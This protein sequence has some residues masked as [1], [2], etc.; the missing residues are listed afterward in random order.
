VL[1]DGKWQLA[2]TAASSSA[3]GSAGATTQPAIDVVV[4]RGVAGGASEVELRAGS[5]GVGAGAKVGLHSGERFGAALVVAAA[6]AYHGLAGRGQGYV[7]FDA[8]APIGLLVG[9]GRVELAVE[10]RAVAAVL[11]A[12]GASWGDVRVV[13]GAGASLGAHVVLSPGWTIDPQL[14][15][16]APLTDR[17]GAAGIGGG[18]FGYEGTS[19]LVTAA[20]GV[21]RA[22]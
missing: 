2:V 7:A 13:F 19:I 11:F 17:A 20:L 4:R 16:L 21:T 18:D 22:W 14:A 12:G 15:L 1:E 3:F 9:G 6:G 10:P 5:A 8:S